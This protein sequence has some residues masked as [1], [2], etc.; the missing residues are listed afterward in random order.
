M[1]HWVLKTYIDKTLVRSSS[2]MADDISQLYFYLGLYLDKM[3]CDPFEMKRK[4]LVV[5]FESQG[6]VVITSDTKELNLF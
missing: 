3:L 6:D 2:V 4:R 5:E 1:A